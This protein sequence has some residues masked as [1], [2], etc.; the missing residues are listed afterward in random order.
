M[1]KIYAFLVVISLVGYINAAIIYVSP[2]G[3][4]GNGGTSWVDAKDIV[5]GIAAATS[6]DEIWVKSGTYYANATLLNLVSKKIYGGF[7][8]NVTDTKENREKSDLDGNGAEESWEFTNQ[9]IIDGQNQ[10]LVFSVSGD[11]A[12]VDGLV[13]QRGYYNATTANKGTGLHIAAGAATNI[14]NVSNCIVRNNK[15]ET[16][17]QT[18][19]TGSIYADGAPGVYSQGVGVTIDGCLIEKNTLDLTTNTTYT[20]AA[21]TDGAGI[22]IVNGCIKNSIIR[23]NISITKIINTLNGVVRGG[24]VFAKYSTSNQSN[25]VAIPRVI[26]CVVA[27]N[28]IRSYGQTT[29]LS[30]AGLYIYDAGY[31]ENCTVVNNKFT[32][33]TNAD[34]TGGERAIGDGAGLYVRLGT[35][36][37]ATFP[38]RY[39]YNTVC[40]GNYSPAAVASGE[41]RSQIYIHTTVNWSTTEFKNV[42]TTE[43][44]Y[45]ASIKDVDCANGGVKKHTATNCII[46]AS[47]DNTSMKFK[48]PSS[49]IG[50]GTDAEVKA[51]WQIDLQSYLTGKGLPITLPVALTTDLMGANYISS[52]PAV[53]AYEAKDLGTVVNQINQT[54]SIYRSGNILYGIEV[55]DKVMA[56]TVTG[57]ILMN[58]ISAVSQLE[59]PRKGY[60]LV[61]VIKNNG[62]VFSVK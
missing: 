53:G 14:I 44:Y 58:K 62:Q 51:N 49:I 50:T 11:G 52:T 3:V 13:F 16:I 23:N 25:P 2:T 60:F 37:S 41:Y 29:G 26:N 18:G 40:W 34:G 7:A 39:V 47:A 55:G 31:V 17:G 33:Y 10:Y 6:T 15:T 28:E 20:T 24:G 46:N 12:V 1:K 4:S 38:N 22:M 19:A 35:N 59:L 9:S 27:N 42:I 21:T 57:S 8:G 32:T 61:K 36:P 43:N 45:G 56:Y 48:M 5:S 30:G 54:S